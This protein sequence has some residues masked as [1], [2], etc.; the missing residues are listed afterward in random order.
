M[1][2]GCNKTSGSDTNE[3]KSTY[4]DQSYGKEVNLQVE[5]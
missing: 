4:K 2:E 1:P 3:L 5:K